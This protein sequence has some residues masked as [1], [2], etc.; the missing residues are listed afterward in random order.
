MRL[1]SVPKLLVAAGV[2]AIG[3]G[4]DSESTTRPDVVAGTYVLE[5]VSGRGPAEGTFLLGSDGWA[6]RQVR[7]AGSSSLEV[8]VGTWQVD[9]GEIAFALQYNP[10]N[11]FMWP[12]R[13]E[14]RGGGFTIRYPD[15]ADGPDIVETY[16]RN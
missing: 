7:Y 11:A 8:M 6:Q 9:D 12:V 2:L 13:G 1:L 16:R 14:W 4:C 15:P 5:S 10:V 3:T